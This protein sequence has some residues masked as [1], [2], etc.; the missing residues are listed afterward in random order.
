MILTPKIPGDFKTELD[1]PIAAIEANLLLINKNLSSK[2]LCRSSKPY[3]ENE[4][5]EKIDRY[6]DLD[7][8][9]EKLCLMKVMV[10]PTIVGA[11]ETVPK[12]GE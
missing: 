11:F 10:I 3:N 8:E 6:L 4:S 2:G 1:L 7:R 12:V 5:E 9:L